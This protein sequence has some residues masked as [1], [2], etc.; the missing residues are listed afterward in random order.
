MSVPS[1]LKEMDEIDQIRRLVVRND[2]R[3]SSSPRPPDSWKTISRG[4]RHRSWAFLF[5]NGECSAGLS[6]HTSDLWL[7]TNQRQRK[8]MNI[9]ESLRGAHGPHRRSTCRP[10]NGRTQPLPS[11]LSTYSPRTDA[12]AEADARQPA[13]LRRDAGSAQGHQH[14]QGPH[15]RHA[16][17]GAA[18][19]GPRRR[20]TGSRRRAHPSS[21]PTTSTRPTPTT[22]FRSLRR[23]GAGRRDRRRLRRHRVAGHRRRLAS[24][25]DVAGGRRDHPHESRLGRPARRRRATC[26]PPGASGPTG[27]SCSTTTSSATSA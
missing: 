4:P 12:L 3:I 17:A 5:P 19:Q 10:K 2:H 20:R 7:L 18:A 11:I 1:R 15:R 14:H 8:T 25:G 9:R 26:R 13:P 22:R 24:A 6:P 21:S 27:R 23:A 16:L